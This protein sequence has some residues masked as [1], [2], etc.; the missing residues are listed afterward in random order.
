MSPLPPT[1]THIY[2]HTLIR[3]FI[4]TLDASNLP[5]AM[6]TLG[7][8]SANLGPDPSAPAPAGPPAAAARPPPCPR[9]R[10]PE[11]EPRRKRAPSLFAQHPPRAGNT[12]PTIPKHSS[13][14][15]PEPPAKSEINL[16]APAPV[17]GVLGASV[18]ANPRHIHDLTPS[19][20]RPILNKQHVISSLLL[21]LLGAPTSAPI[22]VLASLVA[23]PPHRRTPVLVSRT[24]AQPQMTLVSSPLPSPTFGPLQARSGPSK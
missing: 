13:L 15:R 5:R 8:A 2:S 20:F 24:P 11:A 3:T 21:P 17:T 1:R 4:H 22:P 10:V 19:R 7:R 9:Q 16:E 12:R 18:F 14:G 23:E 6:A